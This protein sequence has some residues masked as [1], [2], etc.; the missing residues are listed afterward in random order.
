MECLAFGQSVPP[1][2]YSPKAGSLAQFESANL[3]VSYFLLFVLYFLS[4][5][6]EYPKINQK[7]HHQHL[8]TNSRTIFCIAYQN[9]NNLLQQKKYQLPKIRGGGG[10]SSCHFMQIIVSQVVPKKKDF[11]FAETGRLKYIRNPVLVFCQYKTD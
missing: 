8:L 3:F 10:G 6:S 9:Y 11:F 1:I 4:Q 7:M 2:S 5:F